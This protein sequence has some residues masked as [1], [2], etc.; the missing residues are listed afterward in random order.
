MRCADSDTLT[1]D[2]DPHANVQPDA[3]VQPVA[4]AQPVGDA[5][6]VA[7]PIHIAASH[8]ETANLCGDA[9]DEPRRRRVAKRSRDVD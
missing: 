8:A 1:S 6:P 2:G 7:V 4:N 3:N 5:Q 9:D